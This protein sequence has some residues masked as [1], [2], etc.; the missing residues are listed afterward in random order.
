MTT[1]LTESSSPEKAASPA[2][3]RPGLLIAFFALLLIGASD[4]GRGI[5][6]PSIGTHYHVSMAQLGL[7]YVAIT[8]GYTVTAFGSGLMIERFRLRR[9]L[10]GGAVCFILSQWLMSS[11]PPFAV[12][13]IALLVQGCGIAFLD[14]GLNSFISM[15]PAKRIWLNDLHASYGAG[16]LIGPVIASGILAI[17]LPW[18]AAYVLWAFLGVVLLIGLAAIFRR[19]SLRDAPST[20]HELNQRTLL[21]TIRIPLIW[22]GVLLLIL[23]GGVEVSLGAWSYTFLTEGRGGALLLMAWVVSGFWASFTLGRFV[24]AR[25]AAKIKWAQPLDDLLLIRCCLAGAGAGLLLAWLAP[26]SA[27]AAVGLW[28]TGLSIGPIYPT[29]IAALSNFLPHRL[30]ASAIGVI[31][32]IGGL[33]G[34]IFPWLAG[35]FLQAAGPT[36]LP[37]FALGLVL[38]MLAFLTV[39]SVRTVPALD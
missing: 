1:S 36:A 15:L 6:L 18:S 17:A 32:S 4:G 35:I 31:A 29:T 27:G 24:V 16:A 13:F 19:G 8:V 39:F 34:A 7:F 12:V 2:P 30:V 22:K 3:I 14:I 28:L 25:V 21:T 38:I 5:L 11:M 10:L 33:G 9:V 20:T 26:T 37:L 23:Y